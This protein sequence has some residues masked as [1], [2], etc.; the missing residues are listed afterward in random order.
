MDDGFV[1]RVSRWRAG[2]L[3][4]GALGFVAAAVF[5]MQTKGLTD[6]R[7]LITGWLGALFF[8]ACALVG[9]RQLFST[10]PVMEIDAR[11]ILWRRWSD[12]RIPWSAIERAE[13]MSLGR[14]RFL[15]L[16][17]QDPERYRSAH[18]L[19]RVAGA[20]KSMGFG[21]IALSVSGTDRS[22]ADLAAAFDRYAPDRP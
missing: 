8:G 20:N 17:L 7:A 14:Q 22:F 19:G 4:L 3:V 21:D 16:W 10:G 11:G 1:A 13:A 2:L 12:E 15:A 5:V 9:A 18:M 6:L